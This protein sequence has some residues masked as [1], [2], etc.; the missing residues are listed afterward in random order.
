MH[1]YVYS[2]AHTCFIYICIVHIYLYGCIYS[3]FVKAKQLRLLIK[4]AWQQK[5]MIYVMGSGLSHV[6]GPIIL[7]SRHRSGSGPKDPGP[8]TKSQGPRSCWAGAWVPLGPWNL[9]PCWV[10]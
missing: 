8:G 4:Y 5:N 3:V 9:V 10:L 6:A 1:L 2:Y 7:P